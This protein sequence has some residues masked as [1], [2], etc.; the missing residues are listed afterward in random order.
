MD[1]WSEGRDEIVTSNGL[2]SWTQRDTC[3]SIF[4]FWNKMDSWTFSNGGKTVASFFSQN[5]TTTC[6]LLIWLECKQHKMCSR[7]SHMA[8]LLLQWIIALGFPGY[9]YPSHAAPLWKSER[10]KTWKFVFMPFQTKRRRRFGSGY[11]SWD[12]VSAS[13]QVQS[14]AFTFHFSQTFF[15]FFSTSEMQLGSRKQRE[16]VKN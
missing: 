11:H 2:S 3:A 10:T 12:F 15:F 7:P 8:L 1:W 5:R 9:I 14:V 13:K 16:N 6:P 4:V